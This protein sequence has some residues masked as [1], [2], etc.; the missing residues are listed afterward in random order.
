[1]LSSL[2]FNCG[3]NTES[4]LDN[5]T[6]SEEPSMFAGCTTVPMSV[7]RAPRGHSTPESTTQGLSPSSLLPSRPSRPPG[8]HAVDRYSGGS[9]CT[10]RGC[11]VELL[12]GGPDL[13]SHCPASR[14][15]PVLGPGL[16]RA[17]GGL[18]L[19]KHWCEDRTPEA[20]VRVNGI[21]LP[22]GRVR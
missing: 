1:M 2:F 13:P 19:N 12:L 6:H 9:T 5:V 11:E 22:G 7:P 8:V 16:E 20:P 3:K 4:P 15:G 14:D 21:L 10:L 18:S 17:L